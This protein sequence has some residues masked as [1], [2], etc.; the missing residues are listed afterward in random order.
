[1]A[2]G[3]YAKG[4]QGFL[5][6]SIDFDTD[7]IRLILV[8][9]GA[10]TVDLANHQFLSSI[11]GGARIAT[12]ASGLTGKTATDGVANSTGGTFTGVSG[13]TVEA[14]VMYK[15]TGSDATARLIAYW[16]TGTGLPITPNGGDVTIEPSAGAD[17][18]FK[19]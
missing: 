16:D 1:M 12:L 9:A 15:H 5:D 13:A 18:W 10:Y 17:K 7:D 19:L 8:D 2:N 14:V 6:G 3:L 4:R 11:A